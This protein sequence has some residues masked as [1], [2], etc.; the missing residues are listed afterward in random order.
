M[1]AV[2]LPSIGGAEQL[3]YTE[4]HPIPKLNDG[5]ILVKNNFSGVNFV[6]IYFRKGAYPTRNYPVILGQEAAGTVVAI[7][8]ANP[9]GFNVGDRVVWIGQGGYAEYTAISAGQ[10]I[11]IPEE[12]SDEDA[13]GGHLMGMTALSL[14]EEGFP[15]Q[16]GHTVLVHAAAGGGKD[17]SALLLIF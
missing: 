16:K 7:Q 10:A 2:V 17:Q 4:S 13:V 14:V 3:Q 9:F 8:G 11:K 6:D 1:E 15:V 5:Q 12:V